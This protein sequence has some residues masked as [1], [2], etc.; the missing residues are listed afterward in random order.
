MILSTNIKEAVL[1]LW[2]AK[3]RSLLALIGILVGIGSV[4]AMVS[5]GT[6]VQNEALRQF[7][8]MGT[9]ILSVSVES[10]GNARGG[11]RGGISPDI[12]RRLPDFCPQV[13]TVA[14]YTS[15][16]GTLKYR[17][18]KLD[19]SALGVSPLLWISINCG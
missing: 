12:A 6:I 17:G 5:V 2:G 18:Q 1:S 10:G 15:V 16:F 8:E 11:R 7:R 13:E 4:I 19:I 9:D 3:Q 14:P